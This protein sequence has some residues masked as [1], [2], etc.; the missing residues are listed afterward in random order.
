MIYMHRHVGFIPSVTYHSSH[1]LNS[2]VL[3]PMLGIPGDLSVGHHGQ[4]AAWCYIK[5]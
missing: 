1:Y 3:T 4:E 2:F 5:L